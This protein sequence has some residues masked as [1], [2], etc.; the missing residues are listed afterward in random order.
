MLHY[1]VNYDII[2]YELLNTT[3]FNMLIYGSL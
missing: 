3:N 1:V 2:I